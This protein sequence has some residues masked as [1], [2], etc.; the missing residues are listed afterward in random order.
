M[1]SKE[2]AKELT[3]LFWTSFGKYMQ[4]HKPQYSKHTK[5][6]NYKTGVKDI[7]FRLR[8]DKKSAEIAIEIQHSDEAIRKLFYE[9]L[10]ELKTVFTSIAG[11]WIWE[12]EIYNPQGIKISKIYLSHTQ[13]INIY[14]KDTWADCFHFFEKHI[15]DLDEFWSDFNEIFKNLS[16]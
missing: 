2:E 16:D 9:Q 3:T 4:K 5:W 6:V 15:V 1:F 11:E 14:L 13:P 10:T 12:E 8:A 7:Y